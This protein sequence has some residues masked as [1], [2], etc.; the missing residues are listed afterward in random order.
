MPTQRP[1]SSVPI[2]DITVGGFKSICEK[3]Q[4]E[5]K[6][7]TLLAGANSSG[8]SSIMQPVLLLKQTIE[9]DYDPGA[10]LLD[11]PNAKFTSFDQFSCKGGVAGN[12]QF[13]VGTGLTNGMSTEI[14]FEKI[15]RKGI[16]VNETKYKL[17]GREYCLRLDMTSEEIAKMAK[18]VKDLDI[19]KKSQLYYHITHANKPFEYLN[20]K[21]NTINLKIFRDRCFLLPTSKL[22]VKGKYFWANPLYY[23]IDY[24]TSSI[25][26]MLRNIIHLPGLRGNPQR[27]YMMSASG[28][29]FPGDFTNYV[30]S[31]L[32]S[33][34]SNKSEQKSKLE[35]MLN[36]LGLTNRV[37]VNQIDDSKL[38]IKVGRMPV[39]SKSKSKT[40]DM[41]SIADVGFGVSQT[42]PVLVALLAAQKGRTVYIEQPEIHL[43]PRAQLAMADMLIDAAKRGVNVIAETHSAMILLGIKKR[44]AQGNIDPKLVKMHWFERNTGTGFTNITSV[45]FDRKGSYDADTPEDFGKVTMQA[46]REYLDAADGF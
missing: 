30:A 23:A 46:Q 6:P 4:V 40:K 45:G 26:S 29:N 12:S 36:D 22:E 38:E 42:L 34:N 31:V 32:Y 5:I 41:V 3:Q 16:N 2:S 8:K 24:V 27:N 37:S 10:L 9:A 14:T 18:T 28:P 21:E 17:E 11:G 19:L 44:I 15:P 25:H 33:W 1:I 43:H 39:D 35:K 20:H 13:V 7:L